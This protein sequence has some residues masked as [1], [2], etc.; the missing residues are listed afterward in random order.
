MMHFETSWKTNDNLQIFAQGWEPEG[1]PAKAAVCLVHGVG[2]HTSRYIHVAEALSNGGYVLFGADLRGHGRSEGIRGHFPS[3]EAVMQDMDILLENARKRY[4]HLPLFLYGHSLGGILV[5]HYTLKR[6]TEIRG[7][8]STSPGFHTDLEKQ[9]TKVAAAK[10]LG[11]LFPKLTISSG[12]DSDAICHDKKVVQSYKNDELNHDKISLGF[13]KTMLAINKWTL[14]HAGDFSLPLL[15]MH[16]KE[17]SIAYVSG[18]ID[19]ASRA[20]NNCKLV[21]WENAWHELH[22][23]PEQEEVFSTILQWLNNQITAAAG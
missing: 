7:V 18:S 9:K 5:L 6:E 23:E 16:G 13:G 10:I 11:S 15:L 17:D 19:F 3:A 4:P 8:I 12:L 21:L 1:K 22:N 2:E 20:G 14:E